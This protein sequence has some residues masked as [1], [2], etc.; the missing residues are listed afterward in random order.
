MKRIQIQPEDAL[1][2]GCLALLTIGVANVFGAG[3]ALI[4]VSSLLLI[5]I[6]VPDQRPRA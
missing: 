2:L 6:V 3:W 4:V 1:A 5:Y